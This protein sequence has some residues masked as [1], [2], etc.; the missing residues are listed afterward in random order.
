LLQALAACWGYSGYS[1]GR[2]VAMYA[3]SLSRASTRDALAALLGAGD[4]AVSLG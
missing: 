3:R 1:N 4:T 2:G